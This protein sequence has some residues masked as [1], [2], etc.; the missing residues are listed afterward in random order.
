MVVAFV[1]E[2]FLVPAIIAL[3]PRI[4]GAP[5]VARRLGTAA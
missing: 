3:T 1:A 5:A 4:F 2:V